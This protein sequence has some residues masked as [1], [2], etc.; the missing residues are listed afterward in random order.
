MEKL[1][2]TIA[3]TPYKQ[4]QGLMFVKQMD[5]DR[6]ML[7]IFSRNQSLRFWGENT[8]IPLDIA[9]IDADGIIQQIDKISPFSKRVVASKNTCRYAIE[10][11]DGYFTEH[12]LEIGDKIFVHKD[13]ESSFITFAKKR[14]NEVRT[15][16]NARLRQLL[17]QLMNTEYAYD[18]ENPTE[19]QQEEPQ[20]NVPSLSKEDL[21]QYLE[22]DFDSQEGMYPDVDTPENVDQQQEQELADEAP[23]EPPEI[24]EPEFEYPEFSNAFEALDWAEQNHEVVR[25]SY[26]T[27][28]GTGIARDIEPHG[29]FYAGSTGRQVLVTFDETV[30]D[31]RAFIMKNI[32]SFS[33]VGKKFEPKFRVV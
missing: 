6:G 22:D 13:A 30:G 17:S 29:S 12:R 16:G 27:E 11:V 2:V 21:W 1:Y 14:R 24:P 28:H 18:L 15:G 10:T 4:A 23:V 33:F 5:R 7:F 19:Q 26:T 31:I 25:I 32:H 3:D 9:F 20:P 8:F